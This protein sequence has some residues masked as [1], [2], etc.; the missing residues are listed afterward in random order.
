MKR[1]QRGMDH[2]KPGPNRTAVYLLYPL[3]ALGLILC[4]CNNSSAAGEGLNAQNEYF[5]KAVCMYNFTQFA[6]WPAPKDLAESDV[7]RI[8]IIGKSPFD[9]ALQALQSSLLKTGKKNIRVFY[10]AHYEVE[11]DLT[12]S[13]ILFISSSEQKDMK[14]IVASLG[15]EPVLTISDVDDFL[16]AGGMISL[17]LVDN[18]VRW[19][20][21]RAAINA[22]GI[23]VSSKLLQLA[24]EVENVPG[25][26]ER[27][28]LDLKRE[29]HWP[30]WPLL[31]ASCA[32]S[33]H[34]CS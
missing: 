22:A 23:Q 2:P 11:M 5:L 29:N 16:G 33:S 17:V 8:D 12:R 15:T 20:I 28:S 7:I 1:I 32:I 26:T 9:D 4:S 31:F 13:H 30:L 10:H 19:K 3:V 34:S 6:N 25:H 14:E 24:I 18:K 21:N 27:D